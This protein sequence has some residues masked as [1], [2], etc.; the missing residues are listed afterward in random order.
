MD[1]HN[2]VLADNNKIRQQFNSIIFLILGSFLSAF[3]INVFYTPLMLT[4]GG[5]TGVASIIFQLTGR[6]DFLPL[7]IIIALLNIPL[8]ILGWLKVSWRFVYKSIIGS[9]CYSLAITLTE[10]PM[11]NW[12]EK[13]I[14]K[15]T[16]NGKPDLLIFCLFGGVMFGIAM[17]LILRSGY[18]TGGTDI[19]AVIIHRRFPAI[20]IGRVLLSLDFVIVISSLF[21]YQDLESDTFIIT[22]Y[23]FVAIWLTSKFTDITLEGLAVSRIAYIISDKKHE[24]AAR[25]FVELDRGATSLQAKGM[26]SN[27]ERGMV[28]CVMS[29]RQVPQLKAIVKDIDPAAFVIVTEAREVLGEGFEQDSH[30]FL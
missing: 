10:K 7:G 9:A 6:G 28:F 3:A 25:I 11:A 16:L 22:M 26:F 2:S 23:S 8:L 15:S 21:F 18:T 13:Y 17:G 27:Q 20:S 19:L 30:D 5:V 4:T 24:I 12:F 29:S 1:N 14:N